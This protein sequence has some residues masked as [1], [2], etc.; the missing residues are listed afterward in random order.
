MQRYESMPMAKLPSSFRRRNRTTR[1]FRELFA[2]LPKTIQALTRR[3]CVLFDKSPEHRSLRL[4][5]LKETHGGQH[6]AK[7]YSVSITMQYRAIFVVGEDGV[8]IWYWIGTHGDY[9]K[10]IGD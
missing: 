3:A 6:T 7:S 1:R 4:H 5:Q 8:N 10:F 9:D 2:A